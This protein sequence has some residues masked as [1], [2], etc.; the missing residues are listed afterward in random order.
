MYDIVNKVGYCYMWEESEAK[1]GF[2][3]IGTTMHLLIPI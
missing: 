2:D 3:E 1:S